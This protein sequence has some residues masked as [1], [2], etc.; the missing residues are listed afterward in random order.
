[1][2]ETSSGLFSALRNIAVTLLATGKTRL[3]LLSNEIEAEKRRSAELLFEI[4]GM[5]FCFGV[6]IILAVI[7]LV[8]SFW[9]QRLVVLAVCALAFLA[10]GGISLAR[11][12]QKSR[13]PGRI[14]AVSLAEL[15]RDAHQLSG[16]TDHEP[17]AR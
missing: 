2:G 7:L 12:R 1:M 8:V 14:F 10:L 16:M 3:E 13:R 11:F 6:G 9:E 15:E 17:S 5:T 4:L